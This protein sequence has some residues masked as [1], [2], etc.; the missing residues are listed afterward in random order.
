MESAKLPDL[1]QQLSDAW[2]AICECGDDME[3]DFDQYGD[4]LWQCHGCGASVN[5]ARRES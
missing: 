1:I 3:V 4:V 2:L 5:M